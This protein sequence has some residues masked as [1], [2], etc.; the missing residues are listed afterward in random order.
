MHGGK[1]HINHKYSKIIITDMHHVIFVSILVSTM[2]YILE[3]VQKLLLNEYKRLPKIK[4]LFQKQ[5]FTLY[6]NTT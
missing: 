1:R 5:F 3:D 4:L 2:F 6:V